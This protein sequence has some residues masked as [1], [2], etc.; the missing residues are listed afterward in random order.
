MK[1][2]TVLAVALVMAWTTAAGSEPINPSERLEMLEEAAK[3]SSPLAPEHYSLTDSRAVVTPYNLGK[4]AERFA[5]D[6]ADKDAQALL[7]A[8]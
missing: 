1:L 4:V 5:R 7:S 2:R 6:N 3:A 8:E